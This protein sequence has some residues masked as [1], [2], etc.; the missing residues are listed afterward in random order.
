LAG[1][2]GVIRRPV[3]LTVARVKFG[4]S[5]ST[6]SQAARS[7]SPIRLVVVDLESATN[8][9]CFA[10]TIAGRRVLISFGFG[11]WI[12]VGLL[13]VRKRHA[14]DVGALPRNK[15][16]PDLCQSRQLQQRRK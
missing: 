8:G 15:F 7:Y 9:K 13:R 12:P 1:L 14:A 10:S 3:V 11:Y 16:C 2:V 6:N 4:F 5:F